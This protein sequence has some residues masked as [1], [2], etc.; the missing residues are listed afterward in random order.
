MKLSDFL[1]QTY[2]PKDRVMIF[3]DGSNLY[4][5]LKNEC[6]T[7]NLNYSRFSDLLANKR[8]LIR[9]YFYTST[10][11]AKREPDKAKSQQRFLNALREVPYITIKHRVLLYKADST[12]CGTP[13]KPFEKGIVSRI[14]RTFCN[15]SFTWL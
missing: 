12:T 10:L 4:H 9:T 11:D 2:D 1:K 15:M 13:L 6:G 14:F 5:G 8:K 3:I 7:V